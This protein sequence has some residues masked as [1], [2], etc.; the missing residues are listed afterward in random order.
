[1]Q[2]ISLVIKN[3][4][5]ELKIREEKISEIEACISSTGSFMNSCEALLPCENQGL[6]VVLIDQ[7]VKGQIEQKRC[8]RLTLPDQGYYTVP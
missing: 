6:V 2:L 7:R 1:M 5:I 8:P 4:L 3:H